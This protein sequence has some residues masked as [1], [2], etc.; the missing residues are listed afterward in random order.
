MLFRL[1]NQ[2]LIINAQ[3]FPA[4]VVLMTLAFRTVT[5]EVLLQTGGEPLV[6]P[7]TRSFEIFK[8][9]VLN[10][11]VLPFWDLHQQVAGTSGVVFS[12]TSAFRTIGASYSQREFSF[13]MFFPTN[14]GGIIRH[15]IGGQEWDLSNPTFDPRAMLPE[16]DSNYNVDDPNDF[17][18]GPPGVAG[19]RVPGE[20]LLQAYRRV[21]HGVTDD[22]KADEIERRR[23]ARIAS[24]DLKEV[25]SVESADAARPRNPGSIILTPTQSEEPPPN[26]FDRIKDSEEG[27]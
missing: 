1:D 13:T 9:L 18:S 10:E 11:T 16:I 23:Q 4:N 26:R 25:A 17:D 24:F 7:P 12:G 6:I 27:T 14:G 5:G 2:R 22:K 8:G 19:L 21:H 3:E 20:V 15:S